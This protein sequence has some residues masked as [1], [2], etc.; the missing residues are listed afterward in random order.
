MTYMRAHRIFDLGDW[1]FGWR[2]TPGVQRR[3]IV[4]KL[5]RAGTVIPLRIDGVRRPYFLLAED[6]GR[7]RRHERDASRTRQITD[8]PVRFL[9]PLDNL[10]WRREAGR[11]FFRFY[12]IL[13]V[14]FPPA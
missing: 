14:F 7:L 4:E 2:R 10:L 8:A 5:I 3:P 12:Y 11:G 13:G 1:A 6:E 9:A